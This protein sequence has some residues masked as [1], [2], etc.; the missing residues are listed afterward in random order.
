MSGLQVCSR[1]SGRI[2]EGAKRE[3]VIAVVSI[4]LPPLNSDS[5]SVRS[6]V[7]RAFARLR[8]LKGRLFLL[9]E[10]W[11]GASERASNSSG[12]GGGD[13]NNMNKTLLLRSAHSAERGAKYKTNMAVIECSAAN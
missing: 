12:E 8:S 4:L 9:K 5:V 10:G 11:R 13:G 2:L 6:N 7:S 3:G 1:G